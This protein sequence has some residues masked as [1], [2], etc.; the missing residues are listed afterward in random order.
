M[1]KISFAA[2]AA[3]VSLSVP[4]TAQ[5]QG[6]PSSYGGVM[7]QGFY[8][9]SYKASAWT[10]LEKQVENFKGYF[11]LVWVPQSAYTGGSTSMGYDPLYYFNQKSSFG[12]EDELRSMIATFKENG[13]GTIADV[14]VNH[15]KNVST[16]F[17]FP[18]E[19]YNGVTYQMTSTDIVA[20]DDGGATATEAAS[21]GVTLSGNND[22]GEDWSGMRDLDHKST[23][24]QNCVTAYVKFLKD[25][26]G[27][28]GFRYDMVKGF[29]GSHV[30][31]YNDA[32]G[33]EYSVGEYWDGNASTVKTWINNAS[34]KSAAFDFPFRYTV[35]DAVNNSNWSNLGNSSVMSDADYRQYAV[36]FVENHDTEYRSS[37]EQQDPITADTLAVNAFL[38]AMPGTP[39]V[40]YKHYLAYPEEIKAMIDVRKAAG[41]T[42]TSTYA[43]YRNSTAYFANTVYGDNGTLLVFVGSGYSEPASNR[44][45]KVL[46]GYHYA[47]YLTP[48]TEVAFADKPSGQYTESFQT[49]LTAVSATSGA[50]LV[51]TTN[52]T[53]PTASNGTVVDS[54]TQITIDGST[55]LKVGLLVGSSVTST[56]ERT[57]TFVDAEEED[58]ITYETPDEGY[59]FTAYFIAPTSWASDDDCYAWVWTSTENY[60]GGSWPGDNEHVYRIGQ[61]SD[62]GYIWQWCYYGTLT[63]TPTGIIFNNGSSGVGTNQTK[64]MTF[65][66]GGWYNMSTTTANASL[67]ITTTSA[68]ATSAADGWYTMQGVRIAKPTQRGVYIHDGK[69]VVVN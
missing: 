53:T 10:K 2:L 19:T 66:N 38:L 67:G 54:G 57:Y 36:T 26:L 4:H 63:A 12:T 18:A 51:Y 6:W 42:N 69:K 39:C 65:T 1:K 60:T 55:T 37:S 43:N 35:R 7:L 16:W 13:I 11:D 34:K 31:D 48:A 56:I 68:T 17:D 22:E 3:L 9:D 28:T 30:A 40:F 21:A 62:G 8:W 46:S 49:T 45:V 23:N 58:E 41:V 5:A 32:A 27:Y 33:V 20:D 64:D 14:V 24:V 61:A 25:D 15:R 50:Q 29:A 52:G 59:T 47:M 44:Y